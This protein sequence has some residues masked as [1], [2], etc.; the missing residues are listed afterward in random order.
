MNAKNEPDSQTHGGIDAVGESKMNAGR[1]MIGG[2][3]ISNSTTH[4][5]RPDNRL[6]YGFL[7]LFAIV[8]IGLMGMIWALLPKSDLQSQP[9]ADPQMPTSQGIPSAIPRETQALSASRRSSDS[10]LFVPGSTETSVQTEVKS[11]E[12]ASYSVAAQSGQLMIISSESP[13]NSASIAVLSPD[14]TQLPNERGGHEHNFWVGRLPQTGIYRIHVVA[15]AA[16]ETARMLL[17]VTIPMRLSYAPGSN[18]AT[19]Q[20]TTDDNRIVTYVIRGSS[21]QT[22][23]VNLSAPWGTAALGIAGVNDLQPLN[24]SANSK[25]NFAGRLPATQDYLIQVKPLV[26]APVFYTLEVER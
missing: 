6:A 2:D 13:D 11:N 25:T 4:I 17:T 12:A 7:L 1:D 23:R 14:G 9:Q 19:I 16:A 3:S 22:F 15:G 24:A 5:H 21:G 18:S 8:V 20:G 10:L 26:D